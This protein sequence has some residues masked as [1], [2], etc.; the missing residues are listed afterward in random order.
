MTAIRIK[1]YTSELLGVKQKSLLRRRSSSK[2]IQDEG[3]QYVDFPIRTDVRDEPTPSDFEEHEYESIR[4]LSS[5]TALS[6]SMES[7]VSDTY[8]EITAVSQTNT[9][10]IYVY[11][12]VLD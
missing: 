4:R 5:E 7:L 6:V 1:G 11:T 9:H 12:D 2:V 3:N 10:I 8:M